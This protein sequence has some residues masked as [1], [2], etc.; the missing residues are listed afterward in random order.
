MSITLRAITPADA[1]KGYALTQQAGWP[2]RPEDWL[3]LIQLGEGVVAEQAG[4][5]IGSAMGWR[6]GADSATVGLVVV[7]PRM[8]GGGIGRQLM[9]AL[10][11]HFAG[12]TLRLH[13]T[14]MG[15]GLYQ[16]LGFMPCGHA[17]Q[18]QIGKLAAAPLLPLPPH[19][20]LARADA[21]MGAILCD[22]DFQANGMQRARLLLPL[23]PH[24]IVLRDGDRIQG[25][26]SRRRFGRGWTIGPVIAPDSATAKLLVAALM[27]DL[28]GKFV[29]LDTADPALAAWL[30][31]LGL[32]HVDSPLIMV[33]GT[34]WKPTERV[35]ALA[36]VSPALG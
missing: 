5:V 6:W 3:Q 15:A 8:R 32:Q 36:L 30:A 4:H 29:R 2:H 11:A 33:R 7:D 27:Q 9:Q 16:Q 26:A 17:W 25:F 14:E 35:R 34:P 12:C 24:T 20:I 22:L 23:M 1:D 18:Y 31:T 13:A 21:T 19:L 28:Q 10:I